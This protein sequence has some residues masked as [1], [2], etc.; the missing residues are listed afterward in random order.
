MG[1]PSHRR[2]RRLFN[3]VTWCIQLYRGIP[4][5]F[6]GG[7]CPSHVDVWAAVQRPRKADL[8]AGRGREVEVVPREYRVSPKEI[9]ITPTPF[10]E[11]HP[12]RNAFVEVRQRLFMV[13]NIGNGIGTSL[14][15]DLSRM[16]RWIL[17]RAFA[18]GQRTRMIYS[19]TRVGVFSEFGK[20]DLATLLYA[21]IRGT[22]KVANNRIS[23]QYDYVTGAQ[24]ISNYPPKIRGGLH[25]YAIIS[26][27]ESI[28]QF[29]HYCSQ[30][31]IRLF[32]YNAD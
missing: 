5:P 18:A 24:R 6:G 17:T 12:H 8:E 4:A 3:P 14:G 29:S 1:D 7:W 31:A 9:S 25:R 2:A 32:R 19:D 27:D 20:W 30:Q 21:W 23:R 26:V 16:N 15:L 22:M 11:L 28:V 10:F 13:R